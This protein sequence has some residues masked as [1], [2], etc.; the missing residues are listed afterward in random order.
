MCIF[1]R[2]NSTIMDIKGLLNQTDHF[3]ANAGCKIVEVN[4]Q[5]AVAEMTVTSMHLPK[6]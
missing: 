2:K 4:D 5:H 3:A 1:A 6:E